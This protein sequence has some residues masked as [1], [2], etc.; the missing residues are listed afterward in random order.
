[1][2]PPMLLDGPEDWV[3]MPG[4]EEISL[5]VELPQPKIVA[6]TLNPSVVAVEEV[7]AE[8][9]TVAVEVPAEAKQEIPVPAPEPQKPVTVCLDGPNAG[10]GVSGVAFRPKPGGTVDDVIVWH[11]QGH[12]QQEQVRNIQRG[13]R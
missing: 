13:L 10:D 1:M 12:A 9:K 11:A 6:V 7:R 4:Q 8:S 2:Q 5:P 3:V